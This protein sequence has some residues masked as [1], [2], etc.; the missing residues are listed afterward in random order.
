MTKPVL[1]TRPAGRGEK[2]VSLL[3]ARGLSAEHSP[4]TEFV[5]ETD[6]DLREAVADLARGEFDWLLL[7]SVTTI[8]ALQAL[9]EWAQ[10]PA[11]QE[12]RAAAVG[13]TT[14]A[15]AHAAGLDVQMIAQG[16][17]ASLIE[18]FP[19]NKPGGDGLPQRIFYPVSSAAPAQLETALRMA[20]YDVQ[21]ETAYRP[22]T[23]TQSHDVVDSLAAGGYSAIVATSPMIVRALSQLAIHE[24]TKLVVIGKP[25][26]DAAIAAGLP[27]AEVAATPNDEALANAV[28]KALNI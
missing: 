27:M 14:A 15:A 4:F 10:L 5:F 6:S 16:S 8:K 11:K 7:T 20:G 17:A 18:V 22:K 24:S 3:E 21:R 2:L 12:F 28:A 13:E 1:I 19:V 9:P 23:I 25:S 26:Y